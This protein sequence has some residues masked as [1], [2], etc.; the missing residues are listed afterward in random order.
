IGMQP[1][2]E[3]L[4]HWA[5]AIVEMLTAWRREFDAAADPRPIIG[6]DPVTLAAVERDGQADERAWVQLE[7]PMTDPDHP[8][9]TWLLTEAYWAGE[10]R[11]PA[12]GQALR[13]LQSHI[14][15]IIRGIA[16]G[17]GLRE[18]RREQ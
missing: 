7:I 5:N 17:Y 3:T 4:L 9:A 14:G 1:Q 15:A 6:E 10:V 2:R 16:A 18:R 11:A 12:F 8:A 13:Y